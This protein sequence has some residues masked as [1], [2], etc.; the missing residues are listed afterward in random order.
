VALS[1]HRE[2][3]TLF[4]G[5]DEF[6]AGVGKDGKLDAAAAK[7]KFEATLSRAR[8]KE[9]AHDYLEREVEEGTPALAPHPG[10]A[11]RLTVE[12]IQAAAREKWLAYRAGM[13]QGKDA[14]AE[15]DRA[16]EHEPQKT[17]KQDKAQ[18]LDDDLSL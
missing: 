11:R 18:E 9:L 5:Q 17:P 1:R 8:P 13:T 15:P 2:A 6:A 12:E 14:G 16:Q 3:A 7:A 4:Y 10:P